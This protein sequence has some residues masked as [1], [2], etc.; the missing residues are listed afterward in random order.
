MGSDLIRVTGL[1]SGLDTE[2]IISAYTS[3]YQKKIDNAKK[4]IELGKV[5][6]E[7]WKNLNSKIYSFYANTLST[8]R[9]S[10]AYQKKKT[11]TSNSM[12]SVVPGENAAEGVQTAKI[13]SSAKAAYLTGGKTEITSG[14]DNLSEKLGIAEGEQITFTGKDGT[15]QTFQIGGT[16]ADDSVKVVNT[17]NDLVTGLKNLGVNAN[18]DEGNQRL[19]I[20]AKSTGADNDFT[21]TGSSVETLGK[22]GLASADELAAAG[23][24]TANAMA[25]I[26]GSNAKLTLNGADFESNTN[27]FTIN[28]STYTINGVPA[29]PTE[30]ISVTTGIDYDGVYDVVKS[31]LKEY[32]ELVN[33]MSKLYNADDT[34][35]YAP[36]TSEQKAEMTDQEIEDWETKIKEGILRKDDTVYDVLNTLTNS[37]AEGITVNGQKMY[38]SDFGIATLGYFSAEE[39]E[40]YAL[41]IDG[42]K[43]DS[44]T[45]GNT[46]KLKSMI[47][48]DPSAVTSFFS[49][50]AGN[51][52][53][54]LYAKMGSTSMSSIYKV[55]ND[56]QMESDA[57]SWEK[58][59]SQYEEEL[60]DAEDRY[61]KK[62]SAM[63]TALAKINSKQSSLSGLFS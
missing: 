37:M 15:T 33:E 23:L 48:S 17:M 13:I 10:S 26:D 52:Y 32:N 42:D 39:N 4:E 27:S 29:D 40:R 62:F 14:E 21:I 59:L 49:Q 16:A 54:N 1:N 7:A 24:S 43:D 36:L 2:S 61:Y 5:R 63:E 53:K 47:A 6:T 60:S 8:N 58:K 41:H 44:A 12:L 35:S 20:S 3:K 46:D 30:E 9:L 38:L 45:S 19:F 22:L 18:F 51:L 50:L 28:G 11:T 55:Y 57:K 25:K 31:M 34:S 56:K